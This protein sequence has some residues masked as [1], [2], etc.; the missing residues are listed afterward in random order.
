MNSL[1][2]EKYRPKTLKDMIFDKKDVDKAKQWITDFKNKKKGTPN[3]LFLLGKPGIGKTSLAYALLNDFDYDICEFNASEIRNQ[4]QIKDQISEING[5][6]NVIDFMNSKKKKIGIIMDEIDGMNNNDRG[7][8]TE[9]TDIMFDKKNKELIPSGSPFICISNSIDKKI[10][11]LRDKSVYINCKYP[12]QYAFVNLVTKILKKENIL[13]DDI[14]ILDIIKH[15]Q[16]DIRRLINILEYLF[17]D[18]SKNNQDVYDNIEKELINFD[19]K[20]TTYDIYN[21]TSTILN[22]KCEMDE[23]FEY[24]NTD[25]SLFPLLFMENFPNYTL[26]NRTN[27]Y[28]KKLETLSLAYNSFSYSDIMD[29]SIYLNQYWV[30]NDYN[31]INKCIY[32]ALLLNKLDKYKIN[33]INSISYSSLINK[34]SLEYLNYRYTEYLNNRFLNYS[35]YYFS[36]IISNI[37]ILYFIFDKEASLK[38]INKYEI[39]HDEFNK[40]IKKFANKDI[41]D[42]LTVDIKKKIKLYF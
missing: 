15:S 6:I 3:C 4:K 20:N 8:L 14:A 22:K 35:F 11:A 17:Y 30:L 21:V 39:T 9:L 12:T 25:K 27:D 28:N 33:K 36:E 29:K 24:Y 32:P 18:K 13:I 7:G 23:I 16:N 38:I 41:L 40:K 2:F 42:L 19:K 5:N 10:K 37:L 31:C 26:K 34:T 1:W